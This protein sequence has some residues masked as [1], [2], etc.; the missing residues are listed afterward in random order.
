MDVPVTNFDVQIDAAVRD[1]AARADSAVA[2]VW[3]AFEAVER[4]N[5]R[6]ILAAF[7]RYGVGSAALD[8]SSGYGY[9]STARDAVD[10]VWADALNA[11]AAI[12]RPQIVTGTHALALCLRAVLRPGD[13]LVSITGRPYGTLYTALAPGTG[14]SGGI[15]A[16]RGASYTEIALRPDGTVD[17]ERFERECPRQVRAVLIQRSRGYA[18]RPALTIDGLE[19]IIGV[20]RRIAPDAVTLID[21]C[22]G[23][24]VEAAEPCSVGADLIAGS[25]MKNPG[26]GLAPTGGYVAGRAD[27]VELVAAQLTAPGQG[28]EVGPLLDT[29]RWLLQGLFL[30]PHVVCQALKGAVWGS[31]VAERLGIAVAPRWDEQ[32]GDI[33]QCLMLGSAR[34][35]LGFCRGVQAAGPLDAGA[36]PVGA[37]L[38]GYDCD[39]VMAGG[40]FVQGSSIELSADGPLRE[41]FAV[42]MQGGLSLEHARLGYELGLSRLVADGT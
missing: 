3:R 12:V 31:W 6:R 17:A 5:L 15:L 22:Y 32:R 11:E 33:V 30:A 1:L 18:L 9:G 4:H 27:L 38:P 8:Y 40:T 29:N 10:T 21:N 23:E 34:A 24:F 14:G 39:V 2:D 41:P 13:T 37:P 20:V 7:V 28:R 36:T 26:A 16:E 25:L 42:Y 19:R 35:A